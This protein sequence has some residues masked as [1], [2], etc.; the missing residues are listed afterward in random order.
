MRSFGEA[1]HGA[2]ERGRGGVVGSSRHTSN[3]TSSDLKF[4]VKIRNSE[5]SYKRN[6][7]ISIIKLGIYHLFVELCVLSW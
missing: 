4:S 5:R 7:I 3:R 1:A 2:L 6:P